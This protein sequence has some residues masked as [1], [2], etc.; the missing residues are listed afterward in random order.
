MTKKKATKKKP[1]R[2]SA[3][4]GER[5]RKAG[6]PKGSTTKSLPVAET[7]ATQCPHCLS[8]KRCKKHNST[9]R[10]LPGTLSD[11]TPYTHITWSRVTCFCCTKQRID[12]T[13]TNQPNNVPKRGPKQNPIVAP[14]QRKDGLHDVTTTG[15][16]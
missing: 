3:K 13:Y 1:Q 11:G 7:V 6:R 10:Y 2:R 9:T 5:A 4:P 12:K 14:N 15:A 16:G 8:S